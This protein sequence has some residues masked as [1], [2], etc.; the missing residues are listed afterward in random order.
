M[1]YIEGNT[2]A[3]LYSKVID[4]IYNHPDYISAPKRTKNKGMF[5]CHSS[6]K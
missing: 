2:F 5:K 3:E 1:K 6:V 4:Q